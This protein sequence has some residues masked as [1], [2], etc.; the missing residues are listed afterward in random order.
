M[1][2]DAHLDDRDPTTWGWIHLLLGMVIVAAGLGLFTGA[3]WA[4]AVGVVMAT[5]AMLIAFAWLPSYPIF[6]ILLIAV[7]AAVIWARTTHGLD[8][9]GD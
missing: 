3:V 4:R 9:A 7:S 5:I 8:M 1:R 6:A 2:G